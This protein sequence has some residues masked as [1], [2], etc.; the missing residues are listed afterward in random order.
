MDDPSQKGRRSS[1]LKLRQGDVT[2]ENTD[3]VDDEQKQVFKRLVSFHNVKTVQTFDENNLNL[4]D[5]SPV[6][7]KIQ[8]TM[9]S[10]GVLTPGR[11]HIPSLTP[12]SKADERENVEN[13]SSMDI[14]MT[15]S[16]TDCS[17]FECLLL[18]SPLYHRLL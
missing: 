5:G 10:D 15:D 17:F 18:E 14:T 6:K 8:E 4:L 11:G 12:P 1:I 7:E 9:S 16:V 2:V 13:T 3:D